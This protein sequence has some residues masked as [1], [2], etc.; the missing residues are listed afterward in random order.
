L[1]S[2]IAEPAEY[3]VHDTRA[4]REDKEHQGVEVTLLCKFRAGVVEDIGESCQ[5]H[6]LDGIDSR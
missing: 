5:N 2:N 6:G 3:E 4:Q 1:T